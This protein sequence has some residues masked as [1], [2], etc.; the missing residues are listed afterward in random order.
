MTNTD[1]N[2]GPIQGVHPKLNVKPNIKAV[3]AFISLNLTLNLF[4]LFNIEDLII[5]M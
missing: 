3:I 4:S 1:A 2:I 5:P